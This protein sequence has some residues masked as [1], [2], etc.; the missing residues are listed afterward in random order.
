MVGGRVQKV[1][2]GDTLN[3]RKMMDETF[4]SIV[5]KDHPVLASGLTLESFLSLDHAL[6]SPSRDGT[7]VVDTALAKLG[8]TRHVAVRV[9]H[10]VA[11]P[12][13]VAKT[14]LVLTLP[15][16]IAQTMAEYAPLQVLDTPLDLPGYTHV[17]LWHRRFSQDAGHQWLREQ[18]AL[19][20]Q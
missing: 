13:L 10:F 8:K 4:V 1:S 11:A 6:I 12:I 7:S 18:V 2:D 14:D 20:C 16:R 19:A 3:T 15:R 9:P 17:L 5:R